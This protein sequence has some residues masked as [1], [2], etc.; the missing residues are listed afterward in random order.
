MMEEIWKNLETLE[1]LCIVH[2]YT[3][4]KQLVSLQHGQINHT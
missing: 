3:I 2:P 1:S 4:S